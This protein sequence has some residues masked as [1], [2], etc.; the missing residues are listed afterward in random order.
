MRMDPKGATTAGPVEVTDASFATEVLKSP[1]PVLL[2]CWAPW[3]PPLPVCGTGD[4]RAG[5]RMGRNREGGEA[6]RG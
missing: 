1:L 6:Q 5:R 2:D 4:G 3:C